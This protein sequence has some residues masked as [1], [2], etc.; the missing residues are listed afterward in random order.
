[1]HT[2]VIP[3][4]VLD[5]SKRLYG[6]RIPLPLIPGKFAHVVVDLQN[7]FMAPGGVAETPNLRLIVPNVNKISAAVRKVGG[8][9]IFLRFTYDPHWTNR[10]RRLTP[11]FATLM[12]EAFVEG[13]AQHALWSG[14]DVQPEDLTLNKMR[15]S[16]LTPGTCD[17]EP[18]LQARGIDTLVV[19]GCFS[20]ACCESTSRDAVQMNYNVVFVQD[21]NA[22]VS[23]S[24]HHG[25][26]ADQ[27]SIFGCDVCTADEVVN[28]LMTHVS[29]RKD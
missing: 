17:L 27:F 13:S 19:T 22:T 25:A 7:G 21:G 20:N 12:K 24:D 4:T 18:V 15:F 28:R 29:Q 16:A 10:Y 2:M 26:I 9:N 5:M 3:Q 1:M 23:D 14:L 11:E 8:V 6:E